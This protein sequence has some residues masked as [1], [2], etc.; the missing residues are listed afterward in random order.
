MD[1]MREKYTLELK[2]ME[3]KHKIEFQNLK[4]TN[5]ILLLQKEK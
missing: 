3:E 1:Q 5:E 4:L 2:M